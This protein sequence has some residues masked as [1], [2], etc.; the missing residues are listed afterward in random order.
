MLLPQAC[1]YKIAVVVTCILHPAFLDVS[2]SKR[3]D[4]THYS[5]FFKVEYEDEEVCHWRQGLSIRNRIHTERP[6]GLDAGTLTIEGI[7]WH[8]PHSV[9]W[10]SFGGPILEAR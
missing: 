4:V 6:S 7:R 5:T 1:N 9:A 2:C 3:K 10:G 8:L